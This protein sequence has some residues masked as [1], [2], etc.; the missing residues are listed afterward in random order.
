MT[1][2]PQPHTCAGDNVAR[3]AA[4]HAAG[5]WGPP[6]P[7]GP[8]ISIPNKHVLLLNNLVFNPPP[9]RSCLCGLKVW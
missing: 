9:Y 3:C 4:H 6:S 5:G 7:G 8:D 2:A 1:L